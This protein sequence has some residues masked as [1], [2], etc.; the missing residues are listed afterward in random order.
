MV[1]QALPPSKIVAIQPSRHLAR[2]FRSFI[3]AIICHWQLLQHAPTELFAYIFWQPFANFVFHTVMVEQALPPSKIVAIQPSR[4][5]ARFF[6]SFIVAIICHWQ[7][8]QHAPTELFAY[9]FWQPFANFIFVIKQILHWYVIKNI[10]LCQWFEF[11]FYAF[12]S[13]LI[14]NYC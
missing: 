7:L 9:I 11:I 1:E 2:F 8:L 10:F 6:R 13:V 3:V 4:H 12:L 5:F 14:Q